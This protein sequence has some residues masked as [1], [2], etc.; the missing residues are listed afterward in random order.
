MS[1]DCEEC[2]WSKFF[3]SILRHK[4]STSLYSVNRIPVL[5][6]LERP[7]IIFSAMES[8]AVF[9][10]VEKVSEQRKMFK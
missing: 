2:Q 1:K 3:G 4:S 10:C 7:P 6:M 8:E 9:L 5:L